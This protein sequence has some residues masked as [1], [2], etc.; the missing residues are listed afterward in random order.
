[1]KDFFNKDINVGDFIAIASK[2]SVSH[3]MKMGYVTN[4]NHE[5]NKICFY[6][7]ENDWRGLKRSK[8]KV[9]I[10]FHMTKSRCVILDKDTIPNI[11]KNHLMN[12]ITDIQFNIEEF[13]DFF[14]HPLEVDSSYIIAK[15][16]DNTSIM[17]NGRLLHILDDENNTLIFQ[18]ELE[19]GSVCNFRTKR[20]DRVIKI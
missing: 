6:S 12:P 16:K 2:A 17:E 14:N 13:S 4:I 9:S 10:D 19:D 8:R 18:K 5:S 15:H 20:N 3:T 1:M 7:M 11:L